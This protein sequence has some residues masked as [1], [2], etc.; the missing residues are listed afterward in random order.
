MKKKLIAILLF[1]FVATSLWNICSGN[2]V[3]EPER[4]RIISTLTGEILSRQHYRQHPIDVEISRD[5]Y[6]EFF[7]LLDPGRLYFTAEDMQK[8]EPMRNR[9]GAD[10]LKGD[11]SFAFVAYRRFMERFEEYVA[12]VEKEVKGEFDF[13]AD[14]VFQ[15]DRRKLPWAANDE[16]LHQ[17]WRTKLKSDLLYFRLTLRSMKE[18]D[19]ENGE[20]ETRRIRELWSRNSPEEKILQRLRDLRNLYRQRDDVE[21]LGLYLNGLALAYGPHSAYLTP[22][23][24][25]DF[26]INM[27]LSLTGIGA[28]L[29]SDD[30][31]IRVVSIVPGGPAARDGRLQPE[32]RIIAVTQ[33]GGEPVDV[34]DMSV[35]NAVKLIRGEVGTKVTLT[36]LPGKQG[37]NAVPVNITITR[38]KV[39][40]KDSEAQGRIE[41]IEL[42]GKKTRVGIIELPGFYLD[43]SGMNRGGKDYKSCSRD[44]KKIL[45]D[46]NAQGVETLVMDLRGNGGGSLAEAINMT[47][48]FIKSG[49]VVQIQ[50]ANRSLAVESDEDEAEVW[51]KPMVVLTS[52]MSASASEIFTAALKDYRRAVIAGDTRTFGKG[53]VLNILPLEKML[54]LINRKFPAGS[55]QLETSLFFRINGGTV[56]QLGVEADVVLPSLTEPLEIGEMFSDHHL[57]WTSIDPVSYR[58]CDP[59]LP[60]K[61]EVLR[62]NSAARI[63][64]DPEYQKLIGRIERLRAHIREKTI[65]LNEE[66]R[67]KEYQED[68]SALGD[69]EEE[70]LIPAAPNREKQAKEDDPI[71]REAARVAADLARM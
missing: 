40:L 64:A 18:G 14:E 44:V 39:V 21:I 7:Q 62:K 9:I 5:F 42:E 19:R 58:F 52:K 56:Q 13:T 15:P 17:L 68:R 22:K 71:L 50:Q 3:P 11:A 65:S 43:F 12:F 2:E 51:Q 38:D 46:F 1:L 34:I 49:P 31:Y 61:I 70:E 28:T 69:D 41:E 37:R 36:V 27:S 48:L 53:T 59:E 55:V 47:G 24:D 57:P 25:K 60:E 10:L 8:F 20:D 63:A 26:E 32:D 66:K 29:S 67:W 4:L 35:D 6:D 23:V 45:E 54:G 16:E 33:E 30:G